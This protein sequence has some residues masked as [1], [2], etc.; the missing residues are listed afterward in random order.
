MSVFW[1]HVRVKEDGVEEVVGAIEK[2]FE[3]LGAEQPRGIR[4]AYYRVPDSPSSS[5]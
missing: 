4:Y 2:V 1:I 5:S 3:A